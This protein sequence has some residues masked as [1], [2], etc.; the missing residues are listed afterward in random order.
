MNGLEKT[1]YN[2]WKIIP[3]RKPLQCCYVLHFK[4]VFTTIIRGKCKET[5]E[6]NTSE[7]N[8]VA[9]YH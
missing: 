2:M 6:F 3:L 4:K 9:S 8:G 1:T 5:I 7:S